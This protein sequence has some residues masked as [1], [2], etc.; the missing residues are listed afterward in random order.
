MFAFGTRKL[1]RQGGSFAVTLPMQWIIAMNPDK[2]PIK[3][4]MDNENWLRITTVD[5]PQA[6]VYNQPIK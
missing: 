2:K 4:E 6:T 1:I 3:I 5:T